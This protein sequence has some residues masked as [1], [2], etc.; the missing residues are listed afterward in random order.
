M[1]ADVCVV[2]AAR[3]PPVESLYVSLRR[4]DRADIVNSLEDQLLQAGVVLEEGACQNTDRDSLL[5]PRVTNGKERY[6][7][8]P[9]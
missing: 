5:S 1:Q 7:R 3:L 4:I 6:P 2:S 9:Q 8:S